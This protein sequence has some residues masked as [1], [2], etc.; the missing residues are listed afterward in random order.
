MGLNL[1]FQQLKQIP[2]LQAQQPLLTTLQNISVKLFLSL[3]FLFSL[4]IIGVNVVLLWNGHSLLTTTLG[5]FNELPP[6]FWVDL[7][8]SF[9]QSA[10]ALTTVLVI[11]K[12]LR[13][14]LDRLSKQ[15]QDWDQFTRNDFSIDQFF[16]VLKLHLIPILQSFLKYGIYVWLGILLLATIGID[17]APILAAAGLLGLAVGLGAQNLVN[18]TV[19]GFFILFENYSST[20]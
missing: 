9:L 12:P 3:W 10:I 6:R 5:L 1:S 8:F 14:L 13:K 7:S 17:P 15:L 16:Q 20:Q 11:N 19:S 18:D 4:G 2:R